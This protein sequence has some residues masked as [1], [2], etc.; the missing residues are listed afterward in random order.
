MPSNHAEQ[1]ERV[2]AVLTPLLDD[3]GLDLEAVE[4]KPAG[5]RTLLRVIVDRDGGVALDDL[6]A[7]TSTV[8]KA[9]DDSE[10]MGGG[11]YTV[12]VTS[13]GVDRPLTQPRHWRR[14]FGRLVSVSLSD[15]ERLTGRIASS[16]DTAAELDVDGTARRVPYAEIARA[17]VEV[18]FNR[19]KQARDAAPS[20]E[21]EE[22]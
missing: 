5:R 8:T 10:A 14:N 7:V 6:A 4:L 19:S 9:I 20:G 17:H 11:S 3:A 22:T 13:P 2:A 16:D 12:E 21:D 1:R 18:E 15:G